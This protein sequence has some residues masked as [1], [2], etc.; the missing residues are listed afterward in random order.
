MN[1][2]LLLGSVALAAAGGMLVAAGTGH[3]RDL[4]RFRLIVNNHELI[5]DRLRG[6]TVRAVPWSETLVGGSLL[7]GAVLANRMILLVAGGVG[8][9]M[10]L[11]FSVYSGALLIKRVGG[12]C[13]CDPRDQTAAGWLTV[14][15][16]FALVMF[17]SLGI[18]LFP[19]HSDIFDSASLVGCVA[20]SLAGW[21]L[22]RAPSFLSVIT[23]THERIGG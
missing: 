5:P 17:C 22:L 15:R 18:L 2:D 8:V 21:L 11:A 23:S 3:I 6:P 9:A 1:G 4:A 7:L 16:S 10:G 13:G 19:N 12:E 20:G 14:A